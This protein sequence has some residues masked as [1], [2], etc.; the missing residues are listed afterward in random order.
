MFSFADIAQGRNA[1]PNQV[2]CLRQE[3]SPCEN[4]TQHISFR[5]RAASSWTSQCCHWKGSSSHISQTQQC[6]HSGWKSNGDIR[7][8]LAWWLS[9]Y[10]NQEKD[11]NGR[12]PEA[13][14][15]RWGQVKVFDTDTIYAIAM[16]LQSPRCWQR[17]GSR[18]FTVSN[19]HVWCRWSYAW[20]Q[21]QSQPE[22]CHQSGGIK[23]RCWERWMVV[24]CCEL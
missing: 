14:Q 3:C 6:S 17:N 11:Y 9:W 5:S 8:K 12:Q 13:R 21:N 4:R 1:R 24:L 18:T 2:W 20:S 19:V 10:H 23:P 15:S 7:E 16:G 22:E